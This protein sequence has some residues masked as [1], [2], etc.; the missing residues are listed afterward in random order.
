MPGNPGIGAKPKQN[1]KETEI[2]GQIH[3]LVYYKF[4]AIITPKQSDFKKTN[5]MQG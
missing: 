4:C 1:E 2:L 5:D 3:L